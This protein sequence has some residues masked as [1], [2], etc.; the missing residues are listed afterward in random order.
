MMDADP[1]RWFFYIVVG[2]PRANAFAQ[3]TPVTIT[4][5]LSGWESSNFRILSTRTTIMCSVPTPF[6]PPYWFRS[7]L[8]PMFCN[9]NSF[10]NLLI[11]Y[12]SPRSFNVLGCGTFGTGV[13]LSCLYIW[14]HFCSVKQ[15]FI[16][17]NIIINIINSEAK[18]SFVC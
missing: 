8:W 11:I 12:Y 7:I 5:D 14:G 15:L 6:F 3:S 4:A 13:T 16:I 9:I 18:R 1:L 10:R 17:I 2:S